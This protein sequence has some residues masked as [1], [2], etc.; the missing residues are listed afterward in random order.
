MK[1][2]RYLTETPEYAL[3]SIQK[4]ADALKAEGHDIINLTVGDPKGK[5]FEPLKEIIIGEIKKLRHSQYPQAAGDP[6]Y[7]K[8]VSQWAKD[9]YNIE[10]SPTSEI[11]SCNGSKE[12]IFT[13]PI[14]FDWLNNGKKIFIPELSYPVYEM[15]AGL[16]NIPV[17]K[18]PLK[19][20]NDFLPDLDAITEEEWKSCGLFWINFPH[21][22]T[23]TTAPKSYF[24]KLLDFAKHYDFIVCSDECYNTLYYEERPVSCLEFPESDR[25]LVFRSLSKRSHMT[26]FRIGA[27]M[28]KNKVLIKNLKKMRS[29]M[30]VGTPTFIQKAAITAW[31][32]PYHAI[33]NAKMYKEKRDKLKPVLESKGFKIFGAKAGFYF[34]MSHSH[35]K[36]SEEI[37]TYLLDANILVTPGA[38]FG[39]GGEGFV[40]MVYCD[41]TDI[42][43]EVI[44]RLHALR[45]IT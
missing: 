16:F 2:N 20:E 1:F 15:S 13:I 41:T 3:A 31:N 42:I 32:D 25:W 40:R 44:K 14:A 30:G 19:E 23:T 37:C 8:A 35:L 34:W 39:E 9:D 17:Q 29:A 4:K 6:A 28:S 43:N 45:V 5:T 22:P 33:E 38:A 12:G 7:L 11:V 21:N 27:M 26:G 10:L 36:T 24:K 18:L